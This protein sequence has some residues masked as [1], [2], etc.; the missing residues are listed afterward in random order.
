MS[1][2]KFSR[3]SLF[4]ILKLAYLFLS[5]LMPQQESRQREEGQRVEAQIKVPP[6]H[7]DPQLRRKVPMTMRATVSRGKRSLKGQR[8]TD[9][10]KE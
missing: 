4:V 6:R 8:S 1:R 3:R 10:A 5:S 7:V 2:Q 9:E